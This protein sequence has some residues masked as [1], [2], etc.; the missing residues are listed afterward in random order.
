MKSFTVASAV[1]TL[2]LLFAGPVSA[3]PYDDS[4]AAST[5]DSARTHPNYDRAERAKRAKRGKHDLSPRDRQDS[6]VTLLLPAPTGLRSTTDVAECGRHAA[7]FGGGIVCTAV[8]PKGQLVLVWDWNGVGKL[9]GY[10]IYQVDNG[11]HATVGMQAPGKDI[12]LFVVPPPSNGYTGKC[13][14]VT[15]YMGDQES[16]LSNVFCTEGGSLVQTVTLSPQ[17]SKSIQRFAF[18]ASGVLL[19]ADDPPQMLSR[20]FSVGY[21]Y[22]SDVSKL[23]DNSS[24]NIA[25]TGLYFDMSGVMHKSIR[26][27]RLKL[28]VGTTIIG[29]SY[30]QPQ[31]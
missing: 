27:A 4:P 13:Y 8:L 21:I 23:G 15:A 16:D 1:L 24:T 10:R 20:P 18:H 6:F 19:P 30:G 26:A 22:T 28:T 25:R 12:T 29:G 2:A 17:H 7:V 5:L 14:A 11:L 31:T 3:Q 9:D